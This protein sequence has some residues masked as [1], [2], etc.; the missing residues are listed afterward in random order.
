[1][2]ESLNTFLIQYKYIFKCFYGL[3][4]YSFGFSIFLHSRRFSRLILAKS[5]PWLGGFG[6]LTAVYEWGNVFIPLFGQLQG[7]QNL[8]VFLIL[9]QLILALSL[10]S[11]FQFGIELLRP[12][13]T[14]YRWVRLMPTFVLLVW[15]FGPFIIGF[16]LIPKFSDWISFT[17]GTAAR[18]I[19]I[20]A[21]VV[22]TVGLI[23]QQRRQIK[24]MKLPFMDVMTRIAA[25]GLAA[26]GLFGGVFGPKS[27]LK[28]GVLLS[29]VSFIKTVGLDPH[30]FL[31]I[32]GLVLFYSFT[33]LVEIFDIETEVMVKNMEQEQVIANERERI[34]RDLH[35]GALQQVYASGLLAQSLKK[36]AKPEN[37][38][39]V[40]RLINTI[41]QAIQQLRDFLP[42]KR[43]E[44][45]TVDLVGALQPKIE[46]AKQYVQVKATWE[47]ENLPPLSIDQA[48]HLAA[49]L[50]EAMS[51]VIRHSKSTEMDVKIKYLENLLTIDVRDY[52][53]GISPAA[54]QGYGLRNM[55][56]RAK[57]L[58]AELTIDS[59]HHEGTTVRLELLVKEAI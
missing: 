18:F 52:G 54:E 39:E 31:A 30:L 11:L 8:T 22:S 59:E 17:A 23:H 12:F 9:Q 26:Y 47:T 43:G 58:G 35:D 40:D 49:F 14:R 6:L 7:V 32:A 16:S 46:E 36:R 29:D 15:L 33:R 28:P 41:N 56:E 25:G 3:L 19:C 38:V 5:L 53:E 20:P 10:G 2:I 27:F 45:T 51:N 4:F 55:R 13:S 57:L 24:P 50:N 42:R 48:R 21:S 44:V 37:I 34:A 1:M